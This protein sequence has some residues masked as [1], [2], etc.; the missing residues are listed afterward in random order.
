MRL[1]ALRPHLH[2]LPEQPDLI[3]YRTSYYTE[4]WGFCLPHRL[5]A[6]LPD[7]EYDVCVDTTLADGS[8]TYGE[9]VVPGAG[10]DEIL[11][12][13]HVCHPSLGNDNLSSIALAALLAGELAGRPLRFSYRFLFAPGTIGAITWLAR[14]EDRLH[15]I[16]H[17]L[18]LTCLG[19]PG[20]FTYKR[21]RSG[22]CGTDRAVEHV[23]AHAGYAWQMREFSP[24]G[25]DERQYCCPALT[26]RSA[27]C[28]DR[29][30]MSFPS[31]TRRQTIWSSC[32]PTRSPNP[33]RY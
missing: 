20:P 30:T 9:C 24:Y 5:L 1:P 4:Q 17:G 7:E 12:S 27:D 8:L 26:F 32:V 33:M 3:P 2:S 13:S 15:R 14:N 16:R 25:Y 21:S 6:S 29:R 23:L 11:I 19:D 18:V 10:P 28:P 31:T 22:N